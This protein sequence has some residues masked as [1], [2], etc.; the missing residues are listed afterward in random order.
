MATKRLVL[1]FPANLIDQPLTYQLIKKY[2]L[3]VNILEGAG[4]P[5]GGRSADGR[6]FR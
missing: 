5:Q 4:D 3:M 1:N 2:D 6:N